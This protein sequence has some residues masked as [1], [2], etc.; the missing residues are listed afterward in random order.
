MLEGFTI[1]TTPLTGSPA[2]AE[3]SL[4]LSLSL[5]YTQLPPI[6]MIVSLPFPRRFTGIFYVSSN[7]LCFDPRFGRR[8]LM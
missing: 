4:S 2:A 1:A 8:R 7:D 5:I 6:N 3:L